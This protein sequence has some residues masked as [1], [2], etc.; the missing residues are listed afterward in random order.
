MARNARRL[1]TLALPEEED[2]SRFLI[3]AEGDFVQTYLLVNRF[4]DYFGARFLL[5]S[6]I[7]FLRGFVFGGAGILD[8]WVFGRG[9]G[10]GGPGGI[11]K[12]RREAPWG[13]LA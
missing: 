7:P 12:G 2:L 3:P 9:I 10:Y 13:V 11:L 8:E 1:T 5:L 4:V 6:L